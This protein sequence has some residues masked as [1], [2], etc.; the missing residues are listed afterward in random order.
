[1]KRAAETILNCLKEQ[2]MTQRQLATVMGETVQNINQQLNRQNDI[3]VERFLDVLD[4]LGYRVEIVENDGIR[5]VSPE[6]AEKMLEDKA[7]EGLYWYEG[8]DFRVEG[9]Y[10]KSNEV[11]TKGFDTK[12]ECFDWLKC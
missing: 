12:E 7:P 6:Y 10:I 8:E 4:Y 11:F 3:K 1:M 2:N 9:I 5:K